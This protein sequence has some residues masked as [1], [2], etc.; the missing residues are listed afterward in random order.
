MNKKKISLICGWAAAI[1]TVCFLLNMI[2]DAIVY[3]S[4]LNS[5]PFSLWVL[6]DAI[7]LLLPALGFL[8]AHFYFK[9]KS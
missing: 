9:K 8:A 3:D 2:R 1:C 6:V 4:T 7:L 5:A